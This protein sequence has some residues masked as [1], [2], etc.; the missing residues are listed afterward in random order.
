MKSHATPQDGEAKPAE[1]P[2]H[3]SFHLTGYAME[4]NWAQV[5]W[6]KKPLDVEAKGVQCLRK[7]ALAPRE[8]GQ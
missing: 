1:Y 4:P 3:E 8:I 2:G 5:V 6:L 7:C